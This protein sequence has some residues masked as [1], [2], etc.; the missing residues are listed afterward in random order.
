MPGPG[1]SD[2]EVGVRQF[3]D[4]NDDPDRVFD[5]INPYS[6]YYRLQVGQRRIQEHVDHTEA[7]L[8]KQRLHSGSG[9]GLAFMVGIAGVI[10]VVLW[11]IVVGVAR[12]IRWL[13][14]LG[15]QRTRSSTR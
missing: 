5:G 4:S 3:Y 13:I 2:L 7:M 9:D 6:D 12:L 11:L 10:V 15:L 8:A 14:G 1:S